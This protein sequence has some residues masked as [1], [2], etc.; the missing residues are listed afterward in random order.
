MTNR[1]YLTISLRGLKLS[2][3]DIDLIL[4]KGG[5]DADG[6]ADF[7]ACDKAVYKRIS[8]ILRS[9]LQNVSMGGRST[10]WNMEAVKMFYNALCAENGFR[11]VL[12]SRST[13]RFR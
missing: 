10:S 8:V 4:A 9:T 13:A 12:N 1:H 3:D 11:N 7:G 6:E 5:L 2:E